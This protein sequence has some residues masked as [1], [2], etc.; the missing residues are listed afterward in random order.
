[1][2][3][4]HALWNADCCWIEM[5]LV[6]KI[7]Q[8]VTIRELGLTIEFDRGEEI[9]TEISAKFTSQQVINELFVAGLVA[10]S[11]WQDEFGDF[12]LTM[13]KP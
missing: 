8:T 6:S 9:L 4:H 10:G 2:F 5:R 11:V 13:A 7:A 12:Q 1:M 3:D